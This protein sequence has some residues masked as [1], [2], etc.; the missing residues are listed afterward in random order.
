MRKQDAQ[1]QIIPLPDAREAV[2]RPPS[3]SAPSPLSHA[4]SVHGEQVEFAPAF[5]PGKA[6]HPNPNPDRTVNSDPDPNANCNGKA[7][8]EELKNSYRLPNGKLDLENFEPVVCMDTILQ[9]KATNSNS[10]SNWGQ[11]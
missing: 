6:P 1:R 3:T 9:N 11:G 7:R 4:Q 8:G 10:N 5:Q 2:A